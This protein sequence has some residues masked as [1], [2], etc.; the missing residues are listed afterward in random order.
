MWQFDPCEPLNA[1][2]RVRCEGH[3]GILSRSVIFLRRTAIDDAAPEQELLGVRSKEA[4]D[5]Y[6]R[7]EFLAPPG[8]H[9]GWIHSQ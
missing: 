7:R 3:D 5:A 1:Y 2:S 9:A 4:F 8:R 6:A